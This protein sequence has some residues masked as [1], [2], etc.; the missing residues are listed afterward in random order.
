MFL[1]AHAQASLDSAVRSS[2]DKDGLEGM[3]LLPSARELDTSCPQDA[4][5]DTSVSGVQCGE[6]SLRMSSA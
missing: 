1:H 5:A 2:A 6:I 4:I 3:W